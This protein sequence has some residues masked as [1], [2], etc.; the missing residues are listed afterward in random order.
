M[1]SKAYASGL[2][3]KLGEL[4]DV[5]SWVITWKISGEN[6]PYSNSNTSSSRFSN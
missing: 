2:N 4:A 3:Y 5:G 1:V 6:N